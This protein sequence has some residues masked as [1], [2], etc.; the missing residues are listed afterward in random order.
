MFY[1]ALISDPSCRQVL[2]S[3]LSLSLV[4]VPAEN[5]QDPMET[6]V[7]SST[8]F[9]TANCLNAATVSS[10]GL[11]VTNQWRVTVMLVR[12]FAMSIML[13]RV[14]SMDAPHSTAESMTCAVVRRP[15]RHALPAACRASPSHRRRAC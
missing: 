1:A 15:Y 4:G 12:S 9:L 7:A 2:P 11:E 14:D 6:S 3:S 8:S 10:M 5:V 13:F